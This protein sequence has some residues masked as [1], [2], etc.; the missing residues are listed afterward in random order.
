MGLWMK[1]TLLVLSHKVIKNLVDI[2]QSIIKA[3]PFI[4]EI[5]MI[6]LTFIILN[7]IS[8]YITIDI[9]IIRGKL[10]W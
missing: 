7:S 9:K 10:S 5:I 4:I 2:L 1:I 6:Y 8:L 3:F